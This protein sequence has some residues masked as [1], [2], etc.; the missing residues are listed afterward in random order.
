MEKE[1]SKEIC[2]PPQHLFLV[3]EFVCTNGLLGKDHARTQLLKGVSIPDTKMMIAT[4]LFFSFQ[5]DACSCCLFVLSAGVYVCRIGEEWLHQFRCFWRPFASDCFRFPTW[6]VPVN[7]LTHDPG[8]ATEQREGAE[9]HTA[10][11]AVAPSSDAVK[12]AVAEGAEEQEE[13]DEEADPE[14]DVY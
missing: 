3:N 9:G 8:E 11:T 4:R 14:I 1:R 7:R 12:L 5:G 13:E 6:K 10:S 2:V